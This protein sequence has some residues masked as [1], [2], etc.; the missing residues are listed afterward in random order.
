[1]SG[2]N[3]DDRFLGKAP[4][5]T[6]FF[7]IATF[8]RVPGVEISGDWEADAA[9]IGVPYDGSAGYRPGARFGPQAIRSASG[10]FNLFRTGEGYW[11]IA[12]GERNLK[13]FTVVD[14]GDVEVLEIDYEGTFQRLQSAVAAVMDRGAIPVILGGDHSITAPAFSAVG[15]AALDRGSGRGLSLVHFDAH[16]DYRHSKNGKLHGHGSPIRRCAEEPFAEQIVSLGMRGL[17]ASESDYHEAVERGNVIVPCERIHEEGTAAVLEGLPAL[18]P[19]Y[20]TIDI[21]VLDPAVAPGTGTP[22]V[23]GLSHRQLA[24]LI[25]GIA[26]RSEIIAIDL[27]EVNP[28]FDPAGITALTAAQT[29]IEVLSGINAP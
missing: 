1:M 12:S 27:V 15:G 7:G 9:I 11:D 24:R 26:T 29:I 10:R 23:D 8:A 17:R 28:F 18:G 25:K 2:S 21:D 16:L 6:S 3:G 19:T 22:E 4:S 5:T 20:L 13:G 14:C